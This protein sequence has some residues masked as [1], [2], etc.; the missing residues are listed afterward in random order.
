LLPVEVVPAP[1]VVVAGVL[2]VVGVE[3]VV[4]VGVLGVEA[5]VVEVEVEVVPGCVTVAVLVVEAEVSDPVLTAPL[6]SVAASALTVLAPRLRSDTSV[7]LTDAGRLAISVS[8]FPII[9]LA[10]AHWP[11]DKSVEAVLSS[12]VSELAWFAE[13]RPELAPQAAKNAAA[14][15]SPPARRARGT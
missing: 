2:G 9:A 1:G 14:S 8:T 13:S 15:P 3:E 12:P 6:Q 5:V 10:L 7:G 4:L 11:C